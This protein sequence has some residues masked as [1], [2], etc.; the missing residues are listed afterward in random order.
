[1]VRIFGYDVD[2]HIKNEIKINLKS[3][4]KE[5]LFSGDNDYLESY[6]FKEGK[7]GKEILES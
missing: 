7:T 2:N 3:K 5:K 6:N 4:L 1:M